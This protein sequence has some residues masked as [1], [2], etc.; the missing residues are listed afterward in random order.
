MTTK[1]YDVVDY[2]HSE[3]DI[4]AYLH[5]MLASG[6]SQTAI[7]YAFMDAERARA[8]LANQEPSFQTLDMV[9]GALFDYKN[10]HQPPHS[11]PFYLDKI[12]ASP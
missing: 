6:A 9:F 7:K 2:L 4:Q 5:E 10:N 1:P 3:E 12:I 8:K 11:S